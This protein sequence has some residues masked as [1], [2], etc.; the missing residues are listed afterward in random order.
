MMPQELERKKRNNNS[1]SYR[2]NNN[3]MVLEFLRTHDQF[4]YTQVEIAKCLG[5]SHSVTVH[6]VLRRLARQSKVTRIRMVTSRMWTW[7]L[8]DWLDDKKHDELNRRW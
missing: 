6:N 7:Q 5:L 8:I 2:E 3:K 4:D 1:V